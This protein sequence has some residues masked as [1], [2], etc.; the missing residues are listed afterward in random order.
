MLIQRIKQMGVKV[1]LE[2]PPPKMNIYAHPVIKQ[3]GVKPQINIRNP[4]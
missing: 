2:N 3:M 1:D 4:S